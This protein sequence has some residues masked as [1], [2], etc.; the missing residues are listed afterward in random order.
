MADI[1]Y[2]LVVNLGPS[3]SFEILGRVF[4]DISTLLRFAR[5]VQVLVDQNEAAFR[6]LRERGPEFDEFDFSLRSPYGWPPLSGE[7]ASRRGSAWRRALATRLAEIEGNANIAVERL[8][9]GSP[10]SININFNGDFIARILEIIRDWKQDRRV[11]RAE[12]D[13][14]GAESRARIA[15]AEAYEEKA[16]LEQDIY[17]RLREQLVLGERRALTQQQLDGLNTDRVIKSLVMLEKADIQI[18]RTHDDADES[19]L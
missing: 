15:S 1:S 9:Y 17:R 6:L 18:E 7:F 8:A 13:A 5:D 3:T 14:R 16:R 12:A 19:T 11:A 4:R 10:F 2:R